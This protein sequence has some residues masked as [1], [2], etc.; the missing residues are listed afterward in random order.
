MPVTVGRKFVYADDPAILHYASNWQT[1]KKTLT[2]DMAT[3]SFY[4][5][6]WKL[7]LSTTK[8]VLVTFYLYNKEASFSTDRPYHF[9]L[10]TYLFLT[11]AG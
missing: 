2:Q 3:L 11:Y 9:V 10:L 7:K 4:L 6:K 8:T 5:Y 1:L